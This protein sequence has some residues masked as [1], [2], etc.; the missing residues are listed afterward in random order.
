MLGKPDAGWSK[1]T[2][3]EFEEY[4]SY[5][6]N[7]PIDCLEACIHRV[8]GKGPLAFVFEAEGP[9]RFFVLAT[10]Y[11]TV[12]KWEEDDTP[13]S[14]HLIPGVNDVQLVLETVHDIEQYLND[15]A[16]DWH[17]CTAEE[18]INKL[19]ELKELLPSW[20]QRENIKI[21]HFQKEEDQ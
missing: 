17:K 16:E 18:L 21:S 9:G 4:A 19:N 6:T 15:W 2:M 8:K 12:I 20:Y 7:V 1:V 11:N 14:C 10:A 13:E 5:L 3:G